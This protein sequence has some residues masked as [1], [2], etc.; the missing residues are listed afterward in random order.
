MARSVSFAVRLIL[1][2]A[3]PRRHELLQAAGLT[4]EVVPADVDE[5]GPPDESAEKHVRRL[6]LAKAQAVGPL[7]AGT[8][9]LGADTV[10]TVDELRL[11]KPRDPAE[12]A[13]MLKRLSGRTHLV[14]TGVALASEAGCSSEVATTRVSFSRLTAEAVSWYVASGEP[15]DKAGAYAIQGLASRFVVGIQ[16]S[17]SNVVGLPIE[18]VVR[19][20]EGAGF[21]LWT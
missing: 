2:S 3:S 6:A 9:V 17:Y 18:V 8:L 19:M 20:L 21:P 1:A 15:S 12:A 7:P 16:G 14:L 5:S 4:F 13:W 10:V 11:G